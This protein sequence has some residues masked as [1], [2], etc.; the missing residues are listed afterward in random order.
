MPA[1]APAAWPRQTK[2][3]LAALS[4]AVPCARGHARSVALEWGLPDL[5]ETTELLVSE[6]MTNAIRASH[7]LTASNPPVVRL[8]LIFDQNSIVV[9]VWDGNSELPVRRDIGPDAEGGRGLLLVESLGTD[10]GTYRKDNGK[11][12]WVMI[13]AIRDL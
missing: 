8:W 1:I 4:S 6:L 3:E 11:V 5:A 10:W 7:Q 2:L 13:G 9:H 12:V